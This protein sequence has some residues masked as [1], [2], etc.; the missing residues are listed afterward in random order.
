[1]ANGLPPTPCNFMHSYEFILC[2]QF[3]EFAYPPHASA[4]DIDDDVYHYIEDLFLV[5]LLIDETLQIPSSHLSMGSLVVSDYQLANVEIGL[6]KGF[7]NDRKT[8]FAHPFQKG[9]FVRVCMSLD[10]LLDQI[11]TTLEAIPPETLFSE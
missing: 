6:L 3:Y 1:M 2:S 5:L 8:L 11:R 10:T 7:V 9:Q 4:A